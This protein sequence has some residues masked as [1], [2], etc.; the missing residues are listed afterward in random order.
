[1]T[2]VSDIPS[3]AAAIDL[4]LQRKLSSH[5]FGTPMGKR[6]QKKLVVREERFRSLDNPV[7]LASL[8]WN[9]IHY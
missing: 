1:L 5:F 3:K 7:Y 8:R 4:R 6:W 2:E 9:I